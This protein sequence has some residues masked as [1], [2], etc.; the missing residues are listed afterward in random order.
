MMDLTSSSQTP[1]TIGTGSRGVDRLEKWK[2]K[3][4][5]N[6]STPPHVLGDVVGATFAN[7]D[8]RATKAALDTYYEKFLLLETENKMLREDLI[9]HEEDSLKVV[10]HFEEKL[11]DSMKKTA[12]A[13]QEIDRIMAENKS[14]MNNIMDQYQETLKERDR[15]ISEYASLTERLQRDLRLASRYVQQRQEHTMELKHLHDQLEEMGAKH[16]KDLTALR[17]QTLDRKIKLVSLEKTMRQGFKDIVE[18]EAGRLLD[19]QHRSLLVRNKML[20][21]EK[22]DMAHDIED[23]IQL[24][25]T[26]SKEKEVMRHRADLHQRAHEE[27]LRHAVTVNHQDTKKEEKIQLLEAKLRELLVKYRTVREDTH[28]QYSTRIAELEIELMETQTS[29]QQHRLELR[30]TRALANRVVHQRTDLERFFY[31]ALR[32]CQHYRQQLNKG[33]TGIIALRKNLRCRTIFN[34]S[35]SPTGSDVPSLSDG[36]RSKRTHTTVKGRSTVGVRNTSAGSTDSSCSTVR[37]GRSPHDAYSSST[38]SRRKRRDGEEKEDLFTL[39][40]PAHVDSIEHEKGIPSLI[41]GSHALRTTSGTSSS[42]STHSPSVSGTSQSGKSS[43]V[44]RP[45]FPPVHVPTAATSSSPTPAVHASN[46]AGGSSAEEQTDERNVSN[47]SPRP[48]EPGVYIDDLP[49]ED[50]EKIIKSLL[51]FINSTYYKGA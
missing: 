11:E 3:T 28:Q 33:K 37:I 27:I 51:F 38:S 46:V 25:N 48:P 13:N 1:S 41:A 9:Q 5:K 20:E 49:W 43:S 36:T 7:L 21:E 23:L 35:A 50:K 47:P 32:D 22:V 44:S 31:V 18:E 29:L 2:R 42:S 30:Q 6:S 10:R 24:A 39:Q 45:M 19:L 15:Q 34:P 12:H 14:S 8:L 26:F 4:Q 17:F 40:S 16:E